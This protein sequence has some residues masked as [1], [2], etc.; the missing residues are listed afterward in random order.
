VA[1]VMTKP[2]VDIPRKEEIPPYPGPVKQGAN[3]A[4]VGTWQYALRRRGYDI[5]DAVFGDGTHNCVIDWQ[6]KHRPHLTVDGAFGKNTWNSIWNDPA[7]PGPGN[8]P[9][10][11]RV[12]RR[13]MKG[14]AVGDL[15]LA[16][17][18]RNY[19]LVDAVFGQATFHSIR[20]WQL[21]HGLK[22]DGEGVGGP[23]T[24]HSLWHDK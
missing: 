16:L 15:Y 23:E 14:V 20:D 17:R 19:K 8:A 13:N 9:P 22:K 21:K 3:G 2:Q 10:F 6:K 5:G 4:A 18:R 12:V 1:S 11:R 7:P 24:W